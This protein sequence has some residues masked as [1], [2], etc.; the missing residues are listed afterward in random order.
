MRYSQGKIDGEMYTAV[1]ANRGSPAVDHPVLVIF[2][3]RGAR[4]TV[5]VEFEIGEEV[6]PRIANNSIYIRQD[7]A[8]HGI[9]FIQYQFRRVGG[10]FKM[11]GSESQNMSPREYSGLSEKSQDAPGHKSREVW[12][13]TSVNLLTAR[14]QCWLDT[15]DIDDSPTARMRQARAQDLFERGLAQKPRWSARFAS[16]RQCCCPYPSSNSTAGA[17]TS[18]QAATSTTASA[19]TRQ[20]RCPSSRKAEYVVLA[21]EASDI[22][23]IRAKR[24]FESSHAGAADVRFR[25]KRRPWQLNTRRRKEGIRA[26]RDE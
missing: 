17:I 1:V 10:E 22:L 26:S 5:L 21:I 4:H 19:C 16:R 25:A 23:E 3:S 2:G 14:S 24:C 18:I 20:R 9:R 11:V 13:G 6:S 7:Y 12:S 8:H 15:L